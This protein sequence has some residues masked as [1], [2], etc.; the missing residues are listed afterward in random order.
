MLGKACKRVGDG[1]ETVFRSLE[2]LDGGEGEVS[3]SQ[4]PGLVEGDNPDIRER[5]DRGSSP[6]ED[7]PPSSACDRREDRGW[8]GENEGAGGGDHKQGHGPVEG[9]GRPLRCPERGESQHEPPDEEH[10]G[11]DAEDGPGV[12][13]AKPVGEPLGGGLE[14][15][16]VLDQADDLLEGTL[17]GRPQDLSLQHTPE[18][19]RAREG[20]VSGMLRYGNSLPGHVRLVAGTLSAEHLKVGRDLLSRRHEN[21]HSR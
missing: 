12:A 10:H 14:V 5:L 16:G 6:E 2:D 19:D 9:A 21:P 13:G 11:A 1:S 15:L 8:D 18:I 17:A 3:R 20:R 4:G 7:A